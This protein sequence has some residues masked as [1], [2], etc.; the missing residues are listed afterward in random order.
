MVGSFEES[1]RRLSSEAYGMHG[2][3]VS[4]LKQYHY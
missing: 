2:D 4:V 3:G 1:G